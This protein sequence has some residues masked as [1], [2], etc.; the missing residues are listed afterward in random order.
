MTTGAWL[1]SILRFLVSYFCLIDTVSLEEF[2]DCAD[3]FS[4]IDSSFVRA[5]IC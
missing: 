1:E 2:M 5:R 3:G 4:D